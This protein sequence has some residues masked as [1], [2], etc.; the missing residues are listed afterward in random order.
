MNFKARSAIEI[1]WGLK[2][3][4]L[5]VRTK[6]F[7]AL[8]ESAAIIQVTYK[9]RRRNDMFSYNNICYKL[10]NTN[11][12]E[13]ARTKNFVALPNKNTREALGRSNTT[14]GSWL[15]Y[16]A[17]FLVIKLYNL[18]FV[19]KINILLTRVNI[20]THVLQHW[21]QLEYKHKSQ[22]MPSFEQKK[23]KIPKENI[24]K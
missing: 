1:T 7:K 22:I 21:P 24:K 9:Q 13:I 4:R 16:S 20:R 23:K 15:K 12:H 10:G 5:F 14:H 18:S 19:Y 17:F 6:N 11:S 2:K 3:V 8:Y